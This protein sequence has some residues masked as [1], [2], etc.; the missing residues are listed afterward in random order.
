MRCWSSLFLF[1]CLCLHGC[2]NHFPGSARRAAELWGSLDGSTSASLTVL[3]PPNEAILPRDLAAPRIHWQGPRRGTWLIRFENAATTLHA[4]ATENP[5]VPTE[6]TWAEVR[7]MGA[8]QSVSMRV[9]H[10]DGERIVGMGQSTFRISEHPFAARI[11]YLEIPVPFRHA[12]SVP[13]KFTWKLGDPASPRQ[14]HTALTNMPSCAN[15]HVASND[16]AVIGLDFDHH[17][18]KGG[19]LLANVGKRMQLGPRH[20]F[21]WNAF[22]AGRGVM[23]R[24]LFARISPDGRYVMATVKDQPFLVRIDDPAYSQLFFPLTGRLACYDRQNGRI[25]LLPGADDPNI[26][27]TG[28]AWSAD[29]RTIAFCRGTAAPSLWDALGKRPFLDAPA[30]QDI[31]RLN[32]LH[33]MR[34][35][36]CTV[37]FNAGQGGEATPL[38]GASAN[39]MSNYFPRFTPD[40][41]W[42]V[43]CQAPNGL[44]SQPQSRLLIVPATGGEARVM[45]CNRAELNS[46]HSISPC[47]RWMVFSSKAEP[48]DADHMLGASRLTRIYLTHLD[49]N[50][51]DSPPVLLHRLASS[52]VASILPEIVP[53]NIPALRMEFVK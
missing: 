34:F 18:D 52:G 16:G 5:W 53:E 26:V 6:E 13:E 15:C 28:P 2:A 37:P 24:G 20:V 45:R 47:G 4:V 38:D 27:Q 30:G 22:E 23:S 8:S 40:G 36:L 41:R 14:P 7:N 29:G 10:L 11:L 50:G 35:D 42:I 39:G 31:H 1:V 49:A 12:A 33:R 9:A 51:Q 19:F 3:N 43:F 48:G 25:R 44:V 32:Q 46:W 21:S 17:G